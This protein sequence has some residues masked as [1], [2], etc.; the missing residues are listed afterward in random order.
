MMFLGKVERTMSLNGAIQIFKSITFKT[1]SIYFYRR[2][3]GH[4]EEKK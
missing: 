2:K 3:A 1:T 4:K